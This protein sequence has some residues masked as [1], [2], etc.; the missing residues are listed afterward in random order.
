MKEEELE[1]EGEEVADLLLLFVEVVQRV[2]LRVELMSNDTVANFE[3]EGVGEVLGWDCEAIAEKR[4]RV[5][6]VTPEHFVLLREASNPVPDM[7]RDPLPDREGERVEEKDAVM[8][9]LE[10]GLGE[11]L[12]EAEGERDPTPEKD[13]V[14]V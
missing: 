11:E 6:A 10:L 13:S 8:E 4:A 9:A 14:G 7:D 2:G 5:E 12:A 1:R 3:K